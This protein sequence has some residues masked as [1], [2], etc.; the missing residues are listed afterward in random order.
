MEDSANG[1]LGSKRQQEAIHRAWGTY[2]WWQSENCLEWISDT[3][4]KHHK[5]MSLCPRCTPVFLPAQTVQ[6]YLPYLAASALGN[7]ILW[8][9][10]KFWGLFFFNEGNLSHSEGGWCLLL[11]CNL[12]LY[13]HSVVSSSCPEAPQ[14]RCPQHSWVNPFIPLEP[15]AWRG[16]CHVWA[17]SEFSPQEKRNHRACDSLHLPAPAEAVLLLTT[18]QGQST[19]GSAPAWAAHGG[20]TWHWHPSVAAEIG[21]TSHLPRPH[22]LNL[23][24]CPQPSPPRTPR[25]RSTSAQPALIMSLAWQHTGEEFRGSFESWCA[26]TGEHHSSL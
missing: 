24:L 1:L 22:H 2:F 17:T 4:S 12:L 14:P 20:D 26:T 25:V 18:A 19:G 11:P 15:L 10:K 23:H 8:G 13:V 21:P 6:E 7:V 5:A 9:E 3:L 16:L